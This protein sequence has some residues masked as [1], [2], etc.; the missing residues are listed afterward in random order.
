MFAVIPVIV[1]IVN[2]DGKSLLK[3]EHRYEGA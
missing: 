3:K 2:D 1:A